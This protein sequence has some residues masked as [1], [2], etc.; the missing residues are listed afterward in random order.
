MFVIQPLKCK[1]GDQYFKSNKK[2]IVL[3]FYVCDEME[4]R[5]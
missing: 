3:S 2:S 1:I 5:P 4:N